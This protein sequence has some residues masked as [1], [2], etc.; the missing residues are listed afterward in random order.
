MESITQ[1]NFNFSN[2]AGGHSASV[3]TTLDAQ[4]VKGETLGTVVGDLG[5]PNSFSHDKLQTM[6]DHFICTQ[7]TT[8][9]DPVKTT[10]SRKYVDKTT[11]LLK[12]V[13]VLVRGI[14][15]S[16]RQTLEFEGEVPYFTEVVNAPTPLKDSEGRSFP[17]PK[18][19]PTR[20]GSVIAAGRIYNF[21]STAEFGGA[22]MTLVYNNMELKPE[23][24]LNDEAVSAEYKE[25]PDLSQYDLKY[26]Y[27]LA[28]VTTMLG[29]V[30]VR[31]NPENPIPKRDDILFETNGSLHSV[32]G[33]VASYLGYFW[34]VNPENGW[35]NFINTES[36]S[37]IPINN[38]TTDSA[39][40]EDP[41][42]I[43][44]A[45]TESLVTSKLVNVYSGTS[46]KQDDK[47]PKDD[48]RPRPIFFKRYY[49]EEE[50]QFKA[51]GM[52]H[53]E[54]GSWFGIFNQGEST[55]IF[56]KYT[57]L[58]SW[59]NK[60]GEVE[61]ILGKQIDAGKFYKG[62]F[63]GVEEFGEE[64]DGEKNGPPFN[65]QPWNWGP[66]PKA[67]E[68][69]KGN[70]YIWASD[71]ANNEKIKD[72]TKLK[73]DRVVDE[74]TYML[75]NWDLRKKMPKPSE[76]D[77]YEFLS[78]YFAI[79]GGIFISN[80]Y[81]KYKAERM[82]FQNMNHITVV[83]PLKGD[84][85]LEDVD[86]LSQINDIFKILKVEGKSIKDMAEMTKGE[87]VSPSS[88]VGGYYFVATR[89]IPK[90]E[91][92]NGQLAD[93]AID[94]KPFATKL[95]FYEHPRK[96][97]KLWLG[98]PKEVMDPIGKLAKTVLHQSYLNYMTT[99]DAKKRLRLE[100]V[101]RKTRVNRAPEDSE[102]A[103]DNEI[104]EN[105]SGTESKMSDLF[106]RFDRRYFSVEAPAY[107]LLNNLSLS[108]S[109][110]S[111]VEMKLLKKVRGSYQNAGD[112]PIGSTKTL[113]GL[114]VPLYTVTM[115]AVTFT[116]GP[117]GI[118]TTISESSIKLIP[119]D[120]SILMT[121][122]QE[123]LVN[124]GGFTSYLSA[125]QKNYLGV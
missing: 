29:L 50:E 4:D 48:D 65:M 120:Q 104:A 41:N 21:E 20:N 109:S 10:I 13:V 31:V 90:L 85:L 35:V 23:L 113:Y 95:E 115:N 19:G 70:N 78:N 89:A 28:D 2:A 33:S 56:D 125:S 39:A 79:A 112:K 60:K 30:G 107:D 63:E 64:E 55:A 94:F 93:R 37:Q 26:G 6:F 24:S 38:P 83:G 84:T 80:G 92:H 32:L 105:K 101:R 106:E 58:L 7:Q 11:L 74:F 121:Q 8:S 102:E 1:V 111:T 100:Y 59:L 14:N 69:R 75:C 52:G 67:A 44:A 108:N 47:S 49:I 97:N 16:P 36:A 15:C 9:R 86:S 110:G 91:R 68:E 72:S 62:F 61:P 54:L 17:F 45:Y 96:A 18:L 81:T 114:H 73:Y 82:E 88:S 27:T 22:K 40:E 46:E 3:N 57:Y 25:A 77:L 5:E 118:K 103:E 71:M 124:A 34:Y 117:E 87:S 122:G 51:T 98:G 53:E 123:A 119:P 76:D 99:I 66:A 12:S 116:Q 43:S 42:M